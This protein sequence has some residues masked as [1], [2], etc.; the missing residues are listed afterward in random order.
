VP[1]RGNHGEGHGS[2]V[3]PGSAAAR[4]RPAYGARNVQKVATGTG[5]TLP[6]RSG[7][8]VPVDQRCPIT[9]EEPGSGRGAGRESEAVVVLVE[10]QDNT[11]CGEGRAAASFT[12]K[13]GGPDW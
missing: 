5:E 10:P 7:L 3:D 9:G 1:S 12:R 13:P 8:T 11:T 6:G 2:G 4:N